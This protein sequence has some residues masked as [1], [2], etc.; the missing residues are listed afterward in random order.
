MGSL[1]GWANISLSPRILET[2]D[3]SDRARAGSNCVLLKTDAVGE[4]D[5]SCLEPETCDEWYKPACWLRPSTRHAN[6]QQTMV[7]QNLGF[8]ENWRS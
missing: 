2:R 8:I 7:N 6:A 3:V 1:A 5:A 4:P